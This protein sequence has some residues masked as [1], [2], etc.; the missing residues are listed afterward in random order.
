VSSEYALFSE[1]GARAIVTPTPAKIGAVLASAR[2]YGVGA[3]EI[4][5]VTR[6]STLRIEYKGCTVIAAP[7]P[8]VL[9]TWAHSLER[10]LFRK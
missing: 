7:V 2:Q 3:R 1:R 10:T 5:K 8:A 4:G 6:D 9:D